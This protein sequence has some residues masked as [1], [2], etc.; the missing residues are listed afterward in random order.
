[1]IKIF[2]VISLVFGTE[3][4]KAQKDATFFENTKYQI[5]FET[6]YMHGYLKD[7][8]FSPLNY[9]ENGI[10]YNIN[11]KKQKPN[12]KN[13]FTI[14]L[15]FS[16][17]N[18]YTKASKYFTTSSVIANINL[19]LV[20]KIVTKSKKNICIYLG[21][22]YNSYIQYLDWRDQAA[23]SYIAIHGFSIKGLAQFNIIKK[24][25]IETSLSIPLIQVLARP[26]YNGLDE[27]II[28][29]E[30]NK[31]KLI[32]TGNLTSI[33]KYIAIDWKT[34]YKKPISKKINLSIAYLLR[35]QKVTGVNKLIH[36][37]NL[38]STG[39]NLKF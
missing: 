5:G 11:Y 10:L 25:Q 3:I 1:M 29:N 22:Q 26:P 12:S 27:N 9:V 2:I 15:D 35:Y 14:G 6:G 19:S 30:N 34:C 28:K 21:G 18:L 23:F 7:Q 17:S 33:N 13:I 37:Q 4:L 24:H 39:L 20:S 16:S 8:N 36:F 32:Y 38:L 31:V